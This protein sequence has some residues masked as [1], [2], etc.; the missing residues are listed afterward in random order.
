MSRSGAIPVRVFCAA[1]AK[2][3]VR[4]QS[5]ARVRLGKGRSRK[6]LSLGRRSF[7][8]K[9]GQRRTITVRA[10]KSARRYIQRKKR[11]SVRARIASKAS[12]QRSTLRT[13]RV[14]TVRAR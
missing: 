6:V 7:S 8:L 2:G 12:T 9:A 1:D 13:S 5:V 4:L 14:F 3:T 11:L 10:S